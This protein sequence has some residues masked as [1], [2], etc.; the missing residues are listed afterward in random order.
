MPIHQLALVIADV[1]D[2]HCAG[3]SARERFLRACL[4]AEWDEVASMIEGMLAEPWHLRGFQEMRL[5]EFLKV[6]SD[7]PTQ[8]PRPASAAAQEVRGWGSR[9]FSAEGRRRTRLVRGFDY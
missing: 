8:Q 3:T 9:P 1:I 5:R 6:V 4:G 2:A 7:T